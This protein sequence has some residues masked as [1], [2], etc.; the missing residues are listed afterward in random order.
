MYLTQRIKLTHSKS[1]FATQPVRRV[2]EFSR[3]PHTLEEH[4]PAELSAA[5]AKEGYT[6]SPQGLV[7]TQALE[8]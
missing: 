5:S 8:H 4:P 1:I 3:K 2:N 7:L 6:G